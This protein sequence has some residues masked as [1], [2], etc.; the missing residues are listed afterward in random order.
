MC[1]NL[2]NAIEYDINHTMC[3]CSEQF[4]K[5]KSFFN[6]FLFSVYLFNLV[7]ITLLEFKN[8]YIFIE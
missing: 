1:L 3:I 5:T 7:Y 6:K 8:H 4:V 2:F